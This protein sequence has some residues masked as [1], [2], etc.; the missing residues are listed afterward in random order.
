V[1]VPAHDRE[2]SARFLS[3]VLGV[4]Y[5]GFGSTSGP[6]AFAR[7]RVG[8]TTLDFVDAES[9][10]TEHYAFQVSEQELDTILA[11][12]KDAGLTFSADPGHER[13][14]ELNG[15]NGG[16]GF[17]FSEPN[18]GHNLELLTRPA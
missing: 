1:L 16:R 3:E 4:E 13:E 11:R 2:A 12:V 14:G 18:D 17:Y 8:P 15:W 5:L 7:V 9:F 6:P 10:E